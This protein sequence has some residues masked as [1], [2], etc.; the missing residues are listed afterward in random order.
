MLRMVSEELRWCLT[1]GLRVVSSSW[2]PITGL[3]LYSGM[4]RL[5]SHGNGEAF[6]DAFTGWDHACGADCG[7]RAGCC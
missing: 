4:S 5:I 2:A 7:V 6:P 3:G 1:T